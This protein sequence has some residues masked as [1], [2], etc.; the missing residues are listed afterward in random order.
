MS[1]SSAAFRSAIS[2]A[3]RRFCGASVSGCASAPYCAGSTSTPPEKTMPSRASRVSSTSSS[4]GGMTTARP[5]A[6]S[7]ESTY[8]SGMSAAGRCHTPQLASCAYDVIPMTGLT[9]SS[10]STIQS[11]PSRTPSRAVTRP[12]ATHAGRGRGRRRPPRARRREESLH[13]NAMRVPAARSPPRAATSRSER[14]RARTSR[15]SSPP[16]RPAGLRIT[17]LDAREDGREHRAD[18]LR[19]L[20]RQLFP[21]VLVAEEDAHLAEDV[22]GVELRVHVVE[23]EAE[24]A[25]SVANRPGHRARPAVAR[26]QRRVPVDDA[27][28]RH[29]QRVRWDLPRKPDAERDVGLEQPQERRDPI[30][31]GGHDDVELRRR[32]GQQV[33]QLRVALGVA[34]HAEQSHGLMATGAEELRQPLD[35]RADLRDEN[36]AQRAS[37][38]RTGASAP[39]R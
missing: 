6:R 13:G 37:R 36:D 18:R 7:I 16:S 35:R 9:G 26:E 8:A 3:S 1:R 19:E 15:G 32:G 12:R 27:V 29:R 11:V 31:R 23:R 10:V 34:A 4:A 39:S 33:A 30:P 38:A 28:P 17:A 25:V 5:P 20:R 14:T 22:A 24:L 2:P 21:R